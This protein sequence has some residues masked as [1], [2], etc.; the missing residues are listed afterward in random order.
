MLVT[1]LVLIQSFSKRML[2]DCPKCWPDP[3]DEGH[4]ACLS[5]GGH[6]NMHLIYDSHTC[7]H[8]KTACDSVTTLQDYWWP[9]WP[10][11]KSTNTA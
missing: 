2:V 3:R 8:P 7:D 10:W 5:R 4:L 1:P 11:Q 9:L 6:S